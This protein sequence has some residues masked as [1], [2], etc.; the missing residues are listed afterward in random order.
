MENN[1]WGLFVDFDTLDAEAPP[2]FP[3]THLTSDGHWTRCDEVH[4]YSSCR[5]L[6]EHDVVPALSADVLS[7]AQAKVK[8]NWS[9]VHCSG[10]L[11]Q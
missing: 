4:R 5:Y 9:I 1:V 10:F 7:H 11:T 2:T 6:S 8:R 3:P